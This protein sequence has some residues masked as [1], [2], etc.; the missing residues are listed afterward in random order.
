ML[1][2][3]Q[4]LQ[5]RASIKKFSP[6]SQY[7]NTH[8]VYIYTHLYIAYVTHI[9]AVYVTMCNLQHNA[10]SAVDGIHACSSVTALKYV[11]LPVPTAL[12]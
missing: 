10:H 4:I 9:D 11:V 3:Q 5:V 8:K 7:A 2:H 1:L 6:G 12:Q